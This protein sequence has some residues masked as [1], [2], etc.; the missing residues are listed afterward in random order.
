MATKQSVTDINIY[1]NQR[2]RRKNVRWVLIPVFLVAC[3]L[4][5]YF[6][7]VSGFFAVNNIVIEGNT[8]VEDEEIINIAQIE[9][10]MNIFAV[11][12]N[13]LEQFIPILP[14]VK[15]AVL[16]RKLPC[17]V[18][19]T[20]EEREPVALIN[21]GKATL[22]ID[23]EGRILDRYLTIKDSSLPLVTGI[24][25]TDQGLI[26]GCFITGEQIETALEILSSLPE[27]AD[28]IGEINV[29]D[30]QFIKIYTISGTEIRIGDSRDFDEKYLLYTTIIE[31]NQRKEEAAIKYIDV[32]IISRPAIAYE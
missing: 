5:G 3:L 24:D 21:V 10:G 17:T 20:I 12:S 32:S 30:T 16:K 19:I 6:F 26:P 28:D 2:R 13:A 29:A 4:A 11:N 23:A 7:A 31:E 9:K 15:S 8:R 14:R 1:R 18:I 25:T 22:E 27:N